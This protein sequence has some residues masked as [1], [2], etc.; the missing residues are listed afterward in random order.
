MSRGLLLGTI[1]K[2]NFIVLKE[3]LS[4]GDGV[5]IWTRD[6]VDGAVI[7]KIEKSGKKVQE[8]NAGEEV[9]LFI[10]ALPGTKIYKTSSVN[11]AK[12]ISFVANKEIKIEPRKVNK[13]ILPEIKAKKVQQEQIIVKVYSQKDGFSALKAGAD[14][15][16][17]NILAK[18]FSSAL[19][20]YVP[21]VLNDHEVERV[22]DLIQKNEVKDVLIGDLG[23]YSK[24][25][26]LKINLYMDYSNN[27]FNDFDLNYFDSAT[28]IIST[29]LSF[30]ELTQFKNKDIV[31]MAHG[32]M[33]LMN[34]K[35]ANLPSSLRDEK[36]YVFPVRK[37]HSYYQI[38]NSV[39][40]GWFEEVK[41]LREQG[42]K[43]FYLDLDYDV[44]NVVK[45]YRDILDNKK[46]SYSKK[47]FTKG[48]LDK[49]V[50]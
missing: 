4:V 44:S 12:K 17:Y 42:I 31:A 14:K 5:G 19:G 18:D 32:K 33:V 26:E 2:N 1:D 13:I 50:V 38:L 47:N 37:E 34:T 24:L 6:K 39:E 3:E 35:Y 49:G 43:R 40:Q 8:A 25:A 45:L 11:E 36:G 9:K 29:E 21:R 15:A 22:I 46:V 16:F 28:P 10:H 23:V 7:R 27:L 41:K 48:H 20:A 30:Q